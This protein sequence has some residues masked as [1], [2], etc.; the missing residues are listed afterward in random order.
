MTKT[1]PAVWFSVIERS[2]VQE[3]RVILTCVLIWRG[4]QRRVYLVGRPKEVLR[5]A[6]QFG[7]F[8]TRRRL[9]GKLFESVFDYLEL[10]GNPRDQGCWQFSLDNPTL[11]TM[12]QPVAQRLQSGCPVA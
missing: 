8:L 12:W 11:V 4:Q 7:Q 5:A 2:G 10:L 9:R 3:D 6:R 1:K